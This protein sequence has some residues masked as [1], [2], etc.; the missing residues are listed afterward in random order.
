MSSQSDDTTRPLRMLGDLDIR[1]NGFDTIRLIA[2]LSVI[3]SHAFPLTGVSEPLEALTGG[4]ATI[5]HL[6][7]CVFFL[8]SGYLIPASLDRG[9]LA[10]YASKRA[11]RI[12][13]G[14]T[15]AV[16]LCALVLGPL[17][18]TLQPGEYFA[19][20][21]TWLFLGHAVF[22]P[23]SFDLPGVFR[24]LPTS[25][26]NGSLWSLKFEVACYVIVPFAFAFAHRRVS[27]VL[28]G[29]LAS[30]LIAR[31]IPEGTG[32]ALF[33]IG[34]LAELFRFFGAGMLLY[35]CAGH[36]AMRASW[37]MAAATA[38][39]IAT[40]T[41]VF[42]E[43][44]A[45]AGAYAIIYFAYHAPA[46][47]RAL[48]ARGDISYGVYV[49]AFPIQQL[50]VPISLAAGI[51]GMTAPWLANAALALPAAILAGVL[52]WLFVE[53]PFLTLG[54]RGAMRPSHS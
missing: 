42:V 30:F 23:V 29:W 27:L 33:Y 40:F 44:M 3:V 6:A 5:G 2:A 38:C 7:V 53:K 4:Q 10:R 45:T 16:A 9:S 37:A 22:L 1:N 47:F 15:V 13:P 28:A 12:L 43:A 17:V 41:P 32:G 36:I 8:I 25:A 35:L 26:V 34:L 14:L 39:V 51:S 24:D 50:L 20:L 52:S 31:I 21:S 19:S 46:S 18:T 48:T 54:Q 49:Y 11:F